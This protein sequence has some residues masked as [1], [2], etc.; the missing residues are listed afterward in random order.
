MKRYLS[1]NT[2]RY[3]MKRH[4]LGF[5][6]LVIFFISLVN[7]AAG[8][9]TVKWQYPLDTRVRSSPLVG[10][11][12]TVYIFVG[13]YLYAINPDGSLAWKLTVQSGGSSASTPAMAPDET[14]YLPVDLCDSQDSNCYFALSAIKKGQVQW[15]F[16]M[17]Q[18]TWVSPS[19]ASDG[20]IYTGT[21]GGYL[22]ALNPDGTLKWK[23]AVIHNYGDSFFST[24]PSIGADGTIYIGTEDGYIYAINPDGTLKWRFYTSVFGY[25]DGSSPAIGPDGTVYIGAHDSYLYAINPDGSLKW[26][27]RSSLLGDFESSPAIGSDGTIYIGSRDNFLYAINPDGS[28]QWKFE[29]SDEIESSPAIGADGTIYFG[30]DDHYFY[31]LN[32]DGSLKWKFFADARIVSSPAIES[33]GTII[34]GTYTEDVQAT[35]YIF[36]LNSDSGGLAQTPWPMFR[37]DVMRTGQATYQTSWRTLFINPHPQHGN[38]TSEPAGINCGL[39]NEDCN[40]TYQ[41]NNNVTIIASPDDGY[42]FK[43]W[44]GDCIGCGTDPTCMLIMKNDITCMAVFQGMTVKV[45]DVSGDGKIDIV[46]A[47]FIARHA[48]GLTVNNFN[49]DAADVNCDGH[50]NIVDALFVARKAVGLTVNGWC[51]E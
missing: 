8:S 14:L 31:A 26:K 28:L 27:F 49:K 39:K 42:I 18:S 35:N 13:N 15:T 41:E 51:G 3:D 20:T 33:D 40:A 29:T 38:L 1:P 44:G 16:K 36:A 50:V 10:Q 21:A 30:S 9:G 4:V 25:I 7:Y 48:V 11:Y 32:V 24:A 6:S 45:G 22:Y 12:G 43:R 2:K 46:D 23:S 5:L 17:E 37:H 34:F 19:V 47:L